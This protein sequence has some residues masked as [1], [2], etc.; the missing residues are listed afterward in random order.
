[1]ASLGKLRRQAATLC[2]TQHQMED[3][4]HLNQLTTHNIRV[5]SSHKLRW[6]HSCH[7]PCRSFL[8]PR[9]VP[10]QAH[11]HSTVHHLHHNHKRTRKG[12][13]TNRTLQ[14]LILRSRKHRVRILQQIRLQRFHSSHTVRQSYLQGVCL[15]TNIKPA[16]LVVRQN[17]SR[18]PLP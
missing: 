13:R 15:D 17:T 3:E 4:L 16:L 2:N 11:A 5:R 8:N 18:Q 12:K 1:M 9:V 14:V 7:P 10:P 6:P